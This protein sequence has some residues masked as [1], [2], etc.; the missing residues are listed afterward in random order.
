MSIVATRQAESFV[1]W[2]H[3][4]S[5]ENRLRGGLLKEPMLHFV[6]TGVV[7]FT[8]FAVL[9]PAK[10]A[11]DVIVF[12][13]ADLKLI[14]EQYR[15]TWRSEPDAAEMTALIEQLVREEV[16]YREALALGLD[17][18]DTVIRQ[19]LRQKLEF[20]IAATQE[21]ATPSEAELRAWYEAR[22][23]LYTEPPTLRFEQILLNKAAEAKEVRA[24]LERGANP[25]TLGRAT[26]LP[27]SV[28]AGSAEVDA[29]FG[30]GFAALVAALPVGEWQGPL[31]SSY[32]L[33]LVR[34]ISI[35]LGKAD[36]AS[37]RASVAADWMRAAMQQRLD[38][39]Y[40]AM[41]EAYVIVLP[42]EQPK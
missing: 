28:Q 30:T 25:L 33:H 6:L 38:K 24:A 12:S 26:Q 29:S 9:Q 3:M 22:R 2:G 36:F 21:I 23:D 18:G 16:F 1:D 15:Q 42:G 5:T 27:A 34:V 31:A 20:V 10:I 19:R 35:T 32:G 7:I 4:P 37:V 14:A 13:D 17:Q 41:R 8:L 40:A 39:A 11:S